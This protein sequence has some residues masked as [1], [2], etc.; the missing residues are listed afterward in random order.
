MPSKDASAGRAAGKLIL[1]PRRSATERR[2]AEREF[3]P[4][5][6]EII[7][8][9][10]SPAGRLMIGVIV[11]LVTVAVTWACLG[12]VDIIA[13]A[14]GRLIPAGEV[15][16]IQPLEIGVVKRI[17]VA[18][19]DQV[20]RGDVLI[21]LDPTT[22]GADV[23]RIARDLMQSKLD[24]ARLS[25][26]LTGDAGAFV[27][28]SD[29]DSALVETERRQLLTELAQHRAKLDGIDQQIQA[30]AAERDESKATIA[31]IDATL[32]L[33]EEKVR[34]YRELLEKSLTSKVNLL[35][36]ERQL[37]EAK[38]TRTATEHHVDATVAQVAALTQQ[39]KQTDEELRD[40]DIKELVKA[41]QNAAQ[42]S[43]DGIKARQRTVLQ[44]LRSPVDG[45]VEQLSVHTIGG[46]VTPAQT[47]MAVVPRESKL[48]IEAVLPN[49]EVGFVEI[50]QPA[51]VKIE[52]FSYTRYGLLHG[53]V[54]L[55]G[56]DTLRYARP[57]ADASGKDPLAAKEQPPQSSSE[58][59]SSYMVRIAL[60]E[61]AI[62]TEQGQM[63]LG[64]GMGA[65][66][67]I[68]TGQR[69]VIEY[70]LS[71]IM[72]YRHESLRER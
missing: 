55:V 68:R 44:T 63:Q 32:P 47:L 72:R 17:A 53:I 12:K 42:L 61:T 54:R 2:A 13:V 66:A 5:A 36:S 6:L 51:E 37:V 10:A 29:A 15:K 48:E 18:E 23:E 8:T 69:R 40:Q 41:N 25:A 9:P 60:N 11:L 43:Q 35:E 4:G 64:P 50:G 19:G 65:T 52:A 38:H 57:S 27:V 3:L 21:E 28:P 70:V 46:I 67:E 20:R 14:S 71:P 33:L 24:A 39:W 62:D 59:E 26:Q 7:D 34:M 56:H 30:K 22:T 45:T 49:R 16:L 1:F 58:R 31:K